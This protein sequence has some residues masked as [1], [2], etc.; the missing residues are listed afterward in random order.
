MLYILGT[1]TEKEKR[2][3]ILEEV[4]KNFVPTGHRKVDDTM[5]FDNAVLYASPSGQLIL[6]IEKKKA[7]DDE[8]NTPKKDSTTQK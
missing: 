1:I 6:E 8:Q 5:E 7:V 2:L 3:V 4:D